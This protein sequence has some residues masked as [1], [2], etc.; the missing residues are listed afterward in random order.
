ME[1]LDLFIFLAIFTL[2]VIVWRRHTNKINQD[3]A[4]VKEV[5]EEN[6]GLSEEKL[7]EKV[8]EAYQTHY[9][10]DFSSLDFQKEDLIK[11]HIKRR[12]EEVRRGALT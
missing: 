2:F 5:M 12:I 8:K 3:L 4:L 1:Y 6:P 10:M 11:K 7:V 9:N